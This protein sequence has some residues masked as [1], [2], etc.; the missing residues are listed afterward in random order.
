MKSKQLA[1]SLFVAGMCST[2]A[3]AAVVANLFQSGPDVVANVTGSL[4]LLGLI[5][6]SSGFIYPAL[7][8]TPGGGSFIVTGFFGP[9][10]VAASYYEV[11][12]GPLTFG[13]GPQ[14]GAFPTSGAGL[15]VGVAAGLAPGLIVENSYVSGTPFSSS[16]VFSNH[17]ISSLSMAPGTYTWTWGSGVNADSYTLNITAVPEPRTATLMLLGALALAAGIRRRPL[18][19]VAH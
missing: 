13:A 10:G 8:Q 3:N 18:K 19:V 5:P 17:S 2:T 14:F 12:S 1:V 16:F 11:T 6:V 4:N 15:V 7:Q 9:N